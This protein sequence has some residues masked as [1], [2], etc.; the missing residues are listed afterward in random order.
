MVTNLRVLSCENVTFNYVHQVSL[1]YHETKQYA[2]RVINSY[3]LCVIRVTRFKQIAFLVVL[4]SVK[5]KYN[6]FLK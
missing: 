5:N 3:F 6:M 1:L 2:T 4:S